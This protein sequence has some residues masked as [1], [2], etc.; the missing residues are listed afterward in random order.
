MKT[1]INVTREYEVARFNV[2][3]TFATKRV[4]DEIDIADVSFAVLRHQ[5]GDW[6]DVCVYDKNRNDIA[7]DQG[8]RI[9]SRYRD[10]KCKKFWVITE[11]DRTS[12]TILFPEEY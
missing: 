8:G 9:F 4:L 7:L 10:R 12:T 1:K 5:L 2:G 11:A 6:G 3:N